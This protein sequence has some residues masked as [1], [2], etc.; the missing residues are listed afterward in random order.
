MKRRSLIAIASLAATLLAPLSAQA[1]A[2]TLRV[3]P[4]ANVTILDPIWTTAFVTRNHGYMVYDTLFGTDAAGKV[5]PQMVDK[6]SM[7]KDSLTWTFTLRDGLEF[8]DGKPVTSEDVVA[9]LKRW[10]SRDS[11]GGVLARSVDSY[12]TP[13]AKTFTIKLKAPF[14]VMLEALGKPSSNVPFI[15]PARIAATPGSEQIKEHIG[16]G[17]FKFVTA[18]YKPGERL[19]YAKNEKYKPRAEAPDGT[20]G[21]KPVFIDRVEWVVIRDPQTQF[22]AL[23]AGE[24]DIIEQPTF[25]QYA[26]LKAAK[27]VKLVDAQPDGLQYILRFNHLHPPFDNVKI[28]Q[29]AMVAL[30]QEAFLKTQV[31]AP[32]MYRFCKSMFPCG[33]PFASD[34]T[35]PLFTGAA[36]PKKAQEMLKEAGYNGTPVLLMRPT[37]LASISKLPLVAKQQLE[38]AGFKVDMQQ[39]DWATL[40]AR[41]AKKDAPSAGGWNAFLT[42]WTAGDILN[43]LTMAMMN[44][45][46]DKGW[47]GWQDDPQI[48]EL[49]VKFSQAGTDADKKKLAEQLQLRAFETATH[50]PLGQYNN[51][52]AVRSN[53]SGIVPGGA[54]V[55]WNIKKN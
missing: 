48:E 35:G 41:R 50:V 53:V 47:F 32:G 25:E 14:G 51:P 5:K 7:S 22:N 34:A 30:G 55:Y 10:A 36:N 39:M 24:V 33:T 54:Q 1:Q 13:D 4:H 52:A 15:M 12:A 40:V 2:S 29:A 21:G 37:D 43:P 31:G 9:S 20:A 11:F 38:A 18:E 3:V 42:A 17:P 16:S 49:K 6:W 45:A 26:S 19:V 46:G 44:A 28:R 8:H 27:D 23:L